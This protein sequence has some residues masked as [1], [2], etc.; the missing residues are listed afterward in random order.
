V[1]VEY[2]NTMSQM[3]TGRLSYAYS[4]RRSSEYEEEALFPTPTVA[5]FPAADPEL[6]GFKQFWLADRDRN[7]VRGVLNIQASPAVGV[8]TGLEYNSD[9][10]KDLKFGLKNV[11]SWAFNIDGSFAASERMIF[12]AYY[13]YEDKKSELDSL[14]I[15]RGNANTILD[16]PAFTTPCS[17]YF[18]ATGHLPSDA[19]TDPCRQWA[20]AQSDRVHTFGLGAK[21]TGLLN[22]KLDIGADLAY[23]HAVSPISVSGGAYFG[24]GSTAPAPAFNNIFIAA[25]SF[26]DI[27]SEYLQLRL[28]GIYTLD[29]SSAIRMFYI[30]GH[31][32]T[33]DWQYD[34]YT[35]SSLGPIAIPTFPGIGITSPDYNVHVV[36]VSYL[37]TFR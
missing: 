22:D 21:L 5:P 26:P 18:A 9:H 2:R 3:V 17:G 19:G 28:N 11:R 6:P 31:L 10:Y 36:G 4:Q 12:N 20:E 8:Q 27:T 32:K 7:K 23:S 34:A 35:N 37:Y 30:F 13:T 33:S 29:K 15:G 14:V 24:N 1:R 16:P 25:Q